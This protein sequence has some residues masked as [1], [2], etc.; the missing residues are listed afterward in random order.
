M[1][2]NANVCMVDHYNEY[3]FNNF[4]NINNTVISWRSNVYWLKVHYKPLRIVR[5]L[6]AGSESLLSPTVTKMV[7]QLLQVKGVSGHHELILA[8]LPQMYR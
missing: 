2:A 5:K 1:I 4:V 8:M 6:A 7:V 3:D